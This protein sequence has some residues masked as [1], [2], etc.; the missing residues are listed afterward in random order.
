MRLVSF[1]ESYD[2]ITT[3]VTPESLQRDAFGTDVVVIAY[4]MDEPVGELRLLYDTDLFLTV[5]DI[6]VAEEFRRTDYGTT[7]GIGK[8][9]YNAAFEYAK[10]NG[11]DG[12]R[13]AK[14]KQNKYSSEFWKKY[15]NE[16]TDHYSFLVK[17]VPI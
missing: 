15:G 8:N 16:E 17:S 9:L 14:E 1:L 11:L 12:I 7:Y 4:I 5:Q 3:S 6:T 10:N 2:T 13:S